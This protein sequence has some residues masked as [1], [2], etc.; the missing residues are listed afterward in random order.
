MAFLK[1]FDF[2]NISHIAFMEFYW[3]GHV[4]YTRDHG[5]WKFIAQKY[6]PET[7]LTFPS[8]QFGSNG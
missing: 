6:H 1:K 4:L 7:S 2:V 3:S 5:G 8:Q